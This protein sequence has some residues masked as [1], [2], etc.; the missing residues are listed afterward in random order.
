MA[1][2]WVEWRQTA[3]ETGWGRGEERQTLR[4]FWG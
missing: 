1:G 3:A 4:Q 2:V